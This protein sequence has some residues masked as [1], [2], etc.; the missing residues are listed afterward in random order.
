MEPMGKAACCVGGWSGEGVGALRLHGRRL[1]APRFPEDG[2]R[3][4]IGRRSDRG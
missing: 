1:D 3:R 4:T 2:R